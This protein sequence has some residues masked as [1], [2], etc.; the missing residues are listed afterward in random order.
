MK[1]TDETFLGETLVSGPPDVFEGDTDAELEVFHTELEL[2]NTLDASF[3]KEYLKVDLSPG[4]RLSALDS[5]RKLCYQ[6]CQL[7]GWIRPE[8]E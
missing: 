8:R 6:R 5:R 1:S 4:Q 3:A 7:Y 2:I